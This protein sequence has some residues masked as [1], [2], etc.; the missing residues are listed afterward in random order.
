[1]TSLTGVKFHFIGI[2]GIGMS[3]L[4]ELLHNMGAEVKGSD[5][6]TNSQTERLV[7]LGIKVFSDHNESHLM[8]ADVVVYSS[9]IPKTNAEYLAARK[10]G[11]PIIER[12]EALAEIM[13]LKRGIAIGGT[14]G[15]TTTTSIMGSVFIAGDKKPTIIA[16][17]KVTQLGTNAVLGTGE[18]LIAEADESDGSF[19]RLSP[20]VVI[21]TNIDNDHLEHYGTFE[22]LKKSFYNFA[23]RIPF[24]GKAIVCGDDEE[25]WDLFQDFTKPI[26]F[27]GF[28]ERN[29]Y[30]LKGSNGSYDVCF[31]GKSLGKFTVPMP[32]VHNAL[33][34]C[35]AFVAGHI[36]GLDVKLCAEGVSSFAGVERR[37]HFRGT[38]GEALIYDDYAHHPT[39]IK[40]TIDGF[41]EKYPDKNIHF[42]FQPHRYTRLKSCWGDFL[43]SFSEAKNLVAIPVYRAGESPLPQINS[44]NFIQEIKT[45]LPNLNSKFIADKKQCYESLQKLNTADDIIVCLGAGDNWKLAESLATG[46]FNW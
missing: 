21:V 39:E 31:Q 27:Y 4:A 42:V 35:A 32:G 41:K 40:T 3:G 15:K 37:F 18:W 22:N 17:G 10:N 25:A 29:D 33:N 44:E 11:V 26:A 30:Q 1:M 16:G 43:N 14:H 38:M 46:D 6:S 13:R 36:A 23:M 34:A 2:G 7:G 20:E 19:E 24:Y 12:A 28:G 8:P 45:I 9:A 5:L